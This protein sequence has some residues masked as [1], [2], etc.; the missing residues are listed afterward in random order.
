MIVSRSI[1][2]PVSSRSTCPG[3]ASCGGDCAIAPPSVADT[4]PA[5]ATV[6]VAAPAAVAI[7]A[8]GRAFEPA[9]E[10]R[11]GAGCASRG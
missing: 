2:A 1:A 3:A 8:T 6:A 5:A 9:F 10:P 4:A 11:G 7:D